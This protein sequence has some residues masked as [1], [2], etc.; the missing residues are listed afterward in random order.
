MVV[1]ITAETILGKNKRVKVEHLTNDHADELSTS[2]WAASGLVD[3]LLYT[4]VLSICLFYYNGD[5]FDNLNMTS[6]LSKSG[7][8]FL[9]IVLLD[10]GGHYLDHQRNSLPF[11]VQKSIN[12]PAQIMTNVLYPSIY[13]GGF[14]GYILSDFLFEPK[15]PA[16]ISSATLALIIG[17]LVSIICLLYLFLKMWTS[18]KFSAMN[19]ASAMGETELR[20]ARL[21][22]STHITLVLAAFSLALWAF[23][24]NAETVNY[25]MLLYAAI[26]MLIFNQLPYAIGENN[27]R[28]AL[29]FQVREKIHDL[30]PKLNTTGKREHKETIKALQELRNDRIQI[31]QDHPLIVNYSYLFSG[32]FG[33]IGSELIKKITS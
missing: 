28:Q 17:S 26:G 12:R 25:W 20:K 11:G 19:A 14:I 30:E 1:P 22:E 24:T 6:I 27:L 29:L 31:E 7:I 10:G 23:F 18:A 15:L 21:H 16:I 32:V 8:L 13:I 2:T 5:V 9:L 3:S 4:T 33:W